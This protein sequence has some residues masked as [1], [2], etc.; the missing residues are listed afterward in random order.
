[1]SAKGDWTPNAA[2]APGAVVF[3][4]EGLIWALS[5]ATGWEIWVGLGGLVL[6]GSVIAAAGAVVLILAGGRDR[7]AWAVVSLCISA[8]GV[9]FGFIFWL[10]AQSV[11]C[12]G[13]C[14]D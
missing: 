2:V 11:G 12:G 9:F 13:T 14:F 7:L 4:A 3:V 1:M 6:I 5:A 8:F 10:E